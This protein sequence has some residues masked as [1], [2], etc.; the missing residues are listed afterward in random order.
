[1]VAVALV[2]AASAY[3]YVTYRYS[4]ITTV[5]LPGLVHHRKTLAGA[6]ADVGSPQP[7]AALTILLIGNNTRTGL[8]PADAAHF[9]SDAEVG[10]ARSD[11]TMLLHLDPVHGATILSIPRDLFVPLPPHSMVGSVGKIDAAL[12]DSPEHLI[13]AITNDLGVPI[14][15]YVSINFDGFQ[16]VVNAIGGIHMSFP[17]PL[18]DTESGLNVTT[19]GCQFLNGTEA[20]ELVRARH[21]QYEQRGRWYDDPESDLS[22]IRRD[23]EFLAVLAKTVK[24]KGLT[25]PLRANAVLGSVVNQLTIDDGMSVATMLDLLRRYGRLNPD[26]TPELTLPVTLVPSANYRYHGGT[27]G[28]VVFPTEPAD[29]QVIAQFLDEP[30]PAPRPEHVQVVDWSGV[31]AGR[32]VVAGLTAEGF[33]VAGPTYTP[34]PASP[35]ETVIRYGVG[36][37]TAAERV[38]AALG[39]AVTMTYD[40]GV[41]PGAVVVNAGSVVTVTGQPS[42][43]PAPGGA[44]TTTSIPTPGH[45]P[46]SPAVTPLQSF[47]PTQCASVGAL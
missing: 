29:Q 2:A 36:G 4:Q 37:A 28:S 17:S 45:Q 41:A 9:G 16:N 32:A 31:G 46:I 34:A 10:G 40:P 3:A 7:A 23:H 20:L 47:D 42:A 44:T 21:L 11:V 19:T 5:H 30:P 25:N 24:A 22:R 13:E 15:H 43:P 38:R 27:Y 39:G 35:S 18:R 26:T 8:A 12:N 33:P 14:D 6:V 1:L